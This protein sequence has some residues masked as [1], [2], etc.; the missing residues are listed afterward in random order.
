MGPSTKGWERDWS[1]W[2]LNK[3]EK[4]SWT[5]PTPWLSL[6]LFLAD[7]EQ[8]TGPQWVGL[9]C[10][11]L[12]MQG[13]EVRNS[14]VQGLPPLVYTSQL[15]WVGIAGVAP[16]AFGIWLYKLPESEGWKREHCSLWMWTFMWKKHRYYSGMSFTTT[17][18]IQS[19]K[20]SFKN[21]E[22]ECE[23]IKWVDF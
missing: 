18:I 11:V 22:E 7:R 14:W 10:K 4:P 20:T 12:E 15:L 8:H 16:T 21:E 6:W 19:W 9:L 5:K 1:L 3:G 2:K 17:M 23:I 13:R